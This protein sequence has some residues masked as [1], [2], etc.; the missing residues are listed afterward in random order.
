MH[1]YWPCLWAMLFIFLLPFRA[2]DCVHNFL[3]IF[4]V[5]LVVYFA[6][7]NLCQGSS[8]FLS[9]SL[10]HTLSLCCCS[11][12]PN[13]IPSQPGSPGS[14][15]ALLSSLV[16]SPFFFFFLHFLRLSSVSTELVSVPSWSP[17]RV[18]GP[19]PAPSARRKCITFEMF[20]KW[21][22]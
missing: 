16:V 15:Y 11:C 10:T 9:L 22:P 19:S 20:V 3:P 21:R 6:V 2:S 18:W 7:H 13:S 17:I 1:R 14:S 12:F 4:I 8:L 5:C